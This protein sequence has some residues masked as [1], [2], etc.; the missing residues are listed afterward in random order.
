MSRTVYS[1]GVGRMCPECERPEAAC[2]CRGGARRSRAGAA[3]PPPAAAGGRPRVA[4]EK[5]GRRGKSVTVLRGLPL[6]AAGLAAAA[7]ELK[8]RAGT[9]GTVKEGAIELQGDKVDLAREW[10]VSRGWGG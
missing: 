5:K 10:M 6:D 4:L 2:G 7:K 3:G 1:T 8:A 9:G